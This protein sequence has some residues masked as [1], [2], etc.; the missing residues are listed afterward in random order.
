MFGEKAAPSCVASVNLLLRG[1][2]APRK[3][4][5]GGREAGSEGTSKGEL[6]SVVMAAGKCT[7]GSS[8]SKVKR[9]ARAPL[10][11]LRQTNSATCS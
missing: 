10:V 4:A 7:L 1:T 8:V 2:L 9:D 11:S 5:R 6:L 3:T